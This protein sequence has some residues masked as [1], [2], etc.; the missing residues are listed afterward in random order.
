MKRC[1]RVLIGGARR[2]HRHR[3]GFVVLIVVLIGADAHV[4]TRLKIADVGFIAGS[5]EVFCRTRGRDRGDRL[6]VFLDGNG[7]VANVAQDPDQRGRVGLTILC[8]TALLRTPLSRIPPAGKSNAGTADHDL[9]KTGNG[10][11]QENN[12]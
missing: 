8:R 2:D 4:I 6:I 7:L 12:C 1:E 9:A 5:V 11:Q 10:G 3:D